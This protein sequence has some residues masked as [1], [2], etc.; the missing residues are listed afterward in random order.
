MPDTSFHRHLAMLGRLYRQGLA[1]GLAPAVLRRR[2]G[3][4][5]LAA[6][7]APFVRTEQAGLPGVMRLPRTAAEVNRIA[8]VQ[9]QRHRARILD[10]VR[11][12]LPPRQA[13]RQYLA[14]AAGS[15]PH[16]PERPRPG[17]LDAFDA[18]EATRP[19]SR[20]SDLDRRLEKAF[21]PSGTFSRGPM[22]GIDRQ[23]RRLVERGGRL[24]FADPRQRRRP[25]RSLPPLSRL[26]LTPA[27][28]AAAR[29]VI[30]QRLSGRFLRHWQDAIDERARRERATVR[31]LARGSDAQRERARTLAREAFDRLRPM[32]WRRVVNDPQ[33][34]A[35]L[36]RA[37]FVVPAAGRVPYYNMPGGR[38][39]YLTLDHNERL[40]DAPG[41]AIEG[42]NLTFA[43]GRENSGMLEALRD[44]PFE[45][46]RARP[47]A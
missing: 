41:M 44:A 30:G 8:T 33:T 11:S 5:A 3:A 34:R 32:F 1:G 23:G 36:A 10:A 39:E 15:R 7:D 20:K 45:Q 9:W 26:R 22:R 25:S 28:V 46:A 24:V 29:S 18:D 31:E 35:I 13:L 27:Q 40:A 47:R 43:L 4:L 37:G 12:G 16:S 2:G 42:A 19:P 38:R 6:R 17:A 14:G 21:G